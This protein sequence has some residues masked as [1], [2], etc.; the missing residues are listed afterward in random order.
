TPPLH[1]APPI[2][3]RAPVRRMSEPTIGHGATPVPPY[4]NTRTVARMVESAAETLLTYVGGE[5]R[6]S[7]SEARLEVRN[8]ATAETMAFVPLSAKE[9]VDAAVQ[10]GVTAFREWRNTPVV[11]SEEHTSELQSRENLVCRLLL[12]K[13]KNRE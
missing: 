6:R 7:H 1:D 9:E 12:E 8:P 4:P 2:S 13:K 5:W 3:P 11:R 10:A